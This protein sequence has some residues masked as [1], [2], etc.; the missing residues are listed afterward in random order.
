MTAPTN[1]DPEHRRLLDE[2]KGIDPALRRV[3]DDHDLPDDDAEMM[4]RTFYYGTAR[5]NA[6]LIELGRAIVAPLP[7]W[8]RR[9][10]A[11]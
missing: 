2:E 10:L 7:E 8:L 11:P 4:R 3:L 1:L 9:R 6:A 5:L